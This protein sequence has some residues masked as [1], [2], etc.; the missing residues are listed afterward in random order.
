M[1]TV[2]IKRVNARTAA[3]VSYTPTHRSQ[4]RS[5]ADAKTTAVPSSTSAISIA[6]CSKAT[7]TASRRPTRSRTPPP[8]PI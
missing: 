1:T 4:S 8:T 6:T 7:P 5:N 3:N 2:G